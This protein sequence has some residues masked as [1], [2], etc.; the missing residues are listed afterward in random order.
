MAKEKAE[1]VGHQYKVTTVALDL[2]RPEATKFTHKLNGGHHRSAKVST[3]V[4]N[5][6]LGTTSHFL[7]VEN[8]DCD[9]SGVMHHT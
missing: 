5:V 1:G 2:S 9:F 7:E 4:V 8:N 3:P 6:S